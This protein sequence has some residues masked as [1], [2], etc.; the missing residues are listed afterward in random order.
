[1]ELPCGVQLWEKENKPPQFP[2]AES[3]SIAL[4]DLTQRV[5]R[6]RRRLLGQDRPYLTQL[7]GCSPH[8]PNMAVCCGWTLRSATSSGTHM[9]RVRLVELRLGTH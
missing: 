4:C 2:R 1:V 3:G 7:R 9:Q 6:R 8:T 5:D